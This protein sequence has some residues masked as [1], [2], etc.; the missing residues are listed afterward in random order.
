MTQ[1]TASA[2][3]AS[4]LRIVDI[5]VMADSEPGA[6]PEDVILAKPTGEATPQST[7]AE[8]TPAIPDKFKGKTVEEI[9]DAYQNLEKKFGQQGNDLGEL[10]KMTDQ[11]MLEQLTQINQ[12]LA[13]KAEPAP[14]IT[15]ED[16]LVNPKEV[17]EKLVDERVKN[18]TDKLDSKDQE[19]ALRALEEKHPDMAEVV[20]DVNF[21]EWVL[22][23]AARE[24]NWSK[25][26]QGDMVQA[27]ELFTL[28]KELHKKPEVQTETTET[29]EATQMLD[30]ATTQ[31]PIVDP[32]AVA[33]ATAMQAGDGADAASGVSKAPVFSRRRLVQLQVENPAKYAALAPEI[34]KAYEEKRVVD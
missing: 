10:R 2:P 29:T 21:Q 34:T 1:A 5:D 4:N 13:P 27:D 30:S 23:S 33:T 3:S 8:D 28:Y 15:D 18:I 26:A 9:V 20:Q 11:M 6:N 12:H 31:T 14:E 16:F 25:A 22:S 32:A 7:E 24:A 19:A 17:I